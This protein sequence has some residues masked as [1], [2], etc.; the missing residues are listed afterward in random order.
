VT[1]WSRFR[2]HS[3]RRRGAAGLLAGVLFIAGLLQ[4]SV[5]AAQDDEATPVAP[6][7]LLLVNAG[8][9]SF[10]LVR[11]GAEP[12]EVGIGIGGVAAETGEPIPIASSGL[13]IQT[14]IVID[15]SS[16]SEAFLE[17]FL[18]AAK[19]YIGAAGPN[20]EISVWTTGGASQL[21]VGLNVDHER[22]AN[23]VSEIVTAAGGSLLYDTIRSSAQKLVLSGP[24]ATNVI[25]LAGVLDGGS[26][27]DL[28]GASGAVQAVGAS[29]FSVAVD[30]N[31][32][33]AM[34]SLVASTYGGA[35]ANTE[36]Q[37]DVA[38]YGSSVSQVVNGTYMIP[39]TAA[40]FD[41]SN[42]M[43]VVID[44]TS[45][46]ASFAAGST[47]AGSALAPFAER[48][49]GGVPGFG[50]L[51]GNTGRILG[52]ALG[53]IAAALGA[54]ALVM[55][56]EKDESALTSVLQAYNVPQPGA[57]AEAETG[58]S[59]NAIL[60]RAVQITEDLAER[61]GFLSR[62]EG[63]LERADLPLRGGE[64]LTAGV[65]VAI[66]F[67]VVGLFLTGSWPGMLVFFVLGALFPGFFIRTK[68]RRRQ[69]AFMG[70]LP[71]TLNLLSSTLKAG[72]SFMQG[73]E[74]VSQEIQDPMG[75]ELRRIVTEAQ[76]GRPLEDAMDSSAERM[77]SPDFAWA[78]MAVKIQREVG[79][80]LSE[81][82]LT[83]SE[84]MTE[85]ERL[86][87][88]IASLTAEGKMSA[89]VLAALPILLGLAM[90]AINPEYIATLF[91][92]GFG[93]VLLGSS[94][95]AALAGFAW[96]QKIINIDI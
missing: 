42:Q 85:R 33:P 21:R 58:M 64:A 93:K 1:S 26:V 69:K 47:S 96:M 50:F 83:V 39:F 48:G 71:D 34:R 79:G 2:T 63:T 38:G 14:T 61:R 55:L 77:D 60:K 18:V 89:I 31:V 23:I 17:S 30:D 74:A 25:V 84:T 92:D 68:A 66:A 87:R 5:A 46:R 72:Y 32:A 3:V 41:D 49:A 10:V 53:A 29:A 95:F 36:V 52:L 40:S 86:R 78:V 45:I 62:L 35:F 75:G 70:Q 90:W 7:E 56:M 9:D 12:T 67:A 54:Y 65:G 82:L 94:I 91:T 15:N 88:D 51:A 8:N 6:P 44:G 22:T 11:A 81:L 43:N 13:A 73:V 20:E 76:L 24:G 57:E 59:R 19:S 28:T 16:A 4:V 37:R 80:N 27:V